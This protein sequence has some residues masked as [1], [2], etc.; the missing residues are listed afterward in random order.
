MSSRN[1]P[2]SIY[3]LARSGEKNYPLAVELRNSESILLSENGVILLRSLEKEIQTENEEIVTYTEKRV[4]LSV[5]TAGRIFEAMETE[6]QRRLSAS[7]QTGSIRRLSG[8]QITSQVISE[9]IDVQQFQE[10][11]NRK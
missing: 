2:V 7:F 8:S 11:K 10:I 5:Q 9:L 1:N 6:I 3:S 4:V